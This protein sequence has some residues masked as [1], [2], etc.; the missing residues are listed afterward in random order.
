MTALAHSIDG[1][2]FEFEA[3]TSD[4]ITIGAYV[5]IP[6]EDGSSYLGQVLAGEMTR[7]PASSGSGRGIAGR[8]RV[9]SRYD[10]D[11][12]HSL[13]R[14]AGFEDAPLSLAPPKLVV[15]HF[16]S[17]AGT[18]SALEL[19]RLQGSTEIP[20]RLQ[21]KGFGR[22]TFLCG[23]SGSGK[24]YTLGVVLERLLLD[25]D[26]R[27]VVIDPNSDYVNLGAIRPEESAGA[28]GDEFERLAAR[29]DAVSSNVHVFGGEGSEKRL[30][31]VFGRLSF[32]QQ[33]RVLGLHPLTE[34]EE[35]NAFVRTVRRFEGAEYSLDE[36]MAMIRSSFDDDAR[37]LGLRIDNLGIQRQSIWAGSDEP[38]LEQLPDDWRMLVADIGSLPSPVEGSIAAAAL[39]GFLWE[40]RRAKQPVIVVID[41]AHNICPRNPTDSN[42]ALA[43]EHVVRIAGEG[44]KFGLY[45]L[46][47]TQRPSKV[48]E[49]VISQCDNLLLMKMNSAADLRSL[50]ETFSY[51]PSGLI[52]LASDFQLG[53]GLAAGKIAPDPILFKSGRRLTLE[54][55]SDVPSTWARSR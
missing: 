21:A 19:G 37:R 50:S 8:G 7:S 5:A 11:G 15:D 22:H 43:T 28:A 52:E 25:T 10:G 27:I 20:A 39:L 24:T 55:G 42:Q 51:A 17:A 14:A 38:V 36:L 48:H 6:A 9:L 44:R 30:R 26:I 53:E 18:T 35:Y 32:E 40:A 34:T 1:R 33:S 54:G 13:D 47:S 16:E 29:Y 31:A 2:T 45:L 46:L 4:A 23:Q 12:F 49:N 3:S 41:E